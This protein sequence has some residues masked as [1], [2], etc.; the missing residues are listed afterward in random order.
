M[1]HII[2]SGTT[3]SKIKGEHGQYSAIDP[4]PLGDG[5]FLIPENVLID[6]D[7]HEIDG[8]VPDSDPRKTIEEIKILYPDFQKNEM[9]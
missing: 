8:W 5:K 3:A 6:K 7:L 9:I 2:I 4:I 1:K